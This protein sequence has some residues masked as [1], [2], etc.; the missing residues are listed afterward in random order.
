MA[1]EMTT[2]AKREVTPTE[3]GEVTRSAVVYRPDTDIYETEDHVV[4][5]ADMPGV[6]PADVDVNLERRV[7]TIR[8]HV[9]RQAHDGYRRV[10]AEY[11]EGDYER[12]FTLSEEIDRDRIEASHKNGVL[13]LKMPKAESAKTRKITVKAA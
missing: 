13:T 5:V 4:L 2:T 11:G 7:L 3:Q 8:G 6:A 10:H 12:V 1:Q 9:H